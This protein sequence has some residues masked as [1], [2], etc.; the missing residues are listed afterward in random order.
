MR[1]FSTV[2]GL[3]PLTPAL[4]KGQLYIILHLLWIPYLLSELGCLKILRS[5]MIMI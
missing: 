2:Q 5:H 1:K 3:V 4:F